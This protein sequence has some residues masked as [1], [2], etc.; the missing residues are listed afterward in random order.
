MIPHRDY[1]DGGRSAALAEH[2]MVTTSHPQA[3]LAA[4]DML[5]RGGN[6]VDA[7]LTAV[8]LLGVIEPAMTGIGGDCFALL[9]VK[10]GLPAAFNGSGATPS[11]LDLG[12]FLARGFT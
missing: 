5:R 12:G 9:S 7:A 2:G 10:G 11:G 8:A 6:A 1:R 4:L 3:T